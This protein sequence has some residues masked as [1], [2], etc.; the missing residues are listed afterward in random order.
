MCVSVLTHMI[1]T[2]PVCQVG[3]CTPRH[4]K[5]LRWCG[6]SDSRSNSEVGVKGFFGL[7]V[8]AFGLPCPASASYTDVGI[9]GCKL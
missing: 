5:L 2:I 9:Q 6:G 1:F 7:I 3:A 4:H 8:E